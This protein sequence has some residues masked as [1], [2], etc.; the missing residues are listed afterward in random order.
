MQ[1]AYI[2]VM[3]GLFGVAITSTVFAEDVT[4]QL[5]F[6][7]LIKVV[8]AGTLY[9]TEALAEYNPGVVVLTV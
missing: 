5:A 6:P 2:I 1:S 3:V 8:P 7:P 9:E 4:V